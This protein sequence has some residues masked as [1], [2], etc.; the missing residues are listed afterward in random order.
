MKAEII[1]V[2]T[3][4]LLGDIL[5]SDAQY[6]SKQLSSLGIEM[7]H[8]AVVGDNAKRL[9]EVLNGAFSR[10]DLVITS[11]GLGPTGDDLTKET[12]CK[13]FGKKLVEDAKALE[14]LKD[15]FNK[16]NREMT[17]NNYK[18][19]LVPEGSIV[20]YN[21]NGTAPGIM[22]D[23]NGK[24]LVMLPGPPKE[25]IPMFEKYVRPYLASKQE[26]MFVSRVLRIAK[27]GESKTE[28]VLRDLIE[29][30]TN[31]TIATYVKNIEVI[32][33][34]TAKAKSEE[35]A[36]AL[37][38]PVADEIYKRLGNNVYGEGETTLPEVMC[39]RLLKDKITVAVSESCTGGM[40][41]SAFTDVPGISEIF[42]E[43][44]VTY[45]NE[46]KMRRLGVKKETLD[47]YG[48]VSAQ[49][50][51]EM[52]EGIAKSAGT[53]IGLSTTG[54][55]GPGGGT[56]EKPVGLIYIGL[57][58]YGKTITKELHFTGNRERIRTRTVDAVF[59]AL[60]RELDERE[61]NS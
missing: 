3:E 26:Y 38:S 43:G 56:E 7:Y 19:A 41:S 48:A 35:E 61:Q 4:L 13:I 21:E 29:K 47:K 28:Y 11:G 27:V 25:L 2:G 30:Q 33:R 49:T 60:R 23:E 55:A 1:A 53:D 34:I 24:I 57:C 45:S 31:P 22:I 10:S 42:M 6:L 37:I 44:A 12:G 32:V 59:D 46:A 36:N 58:V 8:Q 50:A 40:L 5:N 20:L 15:F 9:E 16:L 54:I 52:A 39:Q 51:A 18:Q 17:E 14:M